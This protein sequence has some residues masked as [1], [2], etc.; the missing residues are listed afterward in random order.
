MAMARMGGV[1]AEVTFAIDPAGDT[2]NLP[3]Q[4]M[5]APRRKPRGKW[6][7]AIRN[8]NPT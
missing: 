6:G 1:P 3:S 5:S 4:R 2:Q 8:C 7:R